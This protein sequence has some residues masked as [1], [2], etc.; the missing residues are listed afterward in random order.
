M[1]GIRLEQNIGCDHICKHAQK[2][3]NQYI[4]NN[5]QKDNLM[6]ILDIKEVNDGNI[7]PI[8]LNLELKTDI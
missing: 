8:I 2:I 4:K 1:I 5:G 6:L 7:K 3:I